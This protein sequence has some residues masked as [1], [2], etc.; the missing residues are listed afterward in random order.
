MNAMRKEV[1]ITREYIQI[2][3]LSSVYTFCSNRNID[4]SNIHL[5]VA[6]QMNT[7][8]KVILSV[9]ICKWCYSWIPV[10]GNGKYFRVFTCSAIEASM[11][12]I[13]AKTWMLKEFNV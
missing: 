12:N 5:I 10:H 2:K 3:Y 7:I 4:R 8:A 9:I 6:V 13:K 1:I 11:P